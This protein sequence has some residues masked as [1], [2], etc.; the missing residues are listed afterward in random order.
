MARQIFALFLVVALMVSSASAQTCLG[1]PSVSSQISQGGF[2]GG[3]LN[4][5]PGLGCDYTS[6]CNPPL[7]VGSTC[8]VDGDCGS[9]ASCNGPLG[10]RKCVAYANPGETCTTSP[11]TNSSATCQAPSPAGC[12]SNGVCLGAFGDKCTNNND[13]NSGFCTGGICLSLSFFRS[14][15]LLAADSNFSFL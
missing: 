2:C 9:S 4:C 12:S 13:C 7:A 15:P 3:V 8:H 11:T 5:A 10:S 1:F 14:F 6:T